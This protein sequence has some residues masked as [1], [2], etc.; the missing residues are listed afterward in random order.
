MQIKSSAQ[1]VRAG[2]LLE[3]FNIVALVVSLLRESTKKKK[4]KKKKNGIT[5]KEET[6]NTTTSIV[7]VII[8]II[9]FNRIIHIE[10]LWLLF[11]SF[12]LFFIWCEKNMQCNNECIGQ[13][14]HLHMQIIF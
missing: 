4:K 9:M 5:K 1:N 14:V 10:L 7:I 12:R 13:S 2:R 11:Y 8:T 3:L 6:V